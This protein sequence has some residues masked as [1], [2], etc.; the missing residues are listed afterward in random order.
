[1]KRLLVMLLC[2][3]SAAGAAVY[4]QT[5]NSHYSDA[6][7]YVAKGDY[8]SAVKKFTAART[9][10]DVKKIDKDSK[11]YLNVNDQ[12]SK[13]E[14]CIELS[15]TAKENFAPLTDK[16]LDNAIKKC[17]SEEDARDLRN[18]LSAR[19]I[20]ARSALS[21][22]HEMF[23]ADNAAASRLEA[24]TEIENRIDNI[25]Y[26]FASRQEE[27][28]LWDR[29]SQSETLEAYSYYLNYFPEGVHSKE[30]AEKVE[31]LE[32]SDDWE[33]AKRINTT[34]SYEY[35]IHHHPSGKYLAE[36][37][38]ARALCR[39]D[40]FWNQLA[41][42]NTE[43]AYRKYL[44]KYPAGR[45]AGEANGRIAEQNEWNRAVAANTIE[46]YQ[47]YLDNSTI[48][49]FKSEAEDKIVELERVRELAEDEQIWA[50]IEGSDDPASFKRYLDR[51]A[52]K[53]HES[54][55][56]AK[57]WTLLARNIEFSSE[58]AEKIVEA[59]ATAAKYT[60]LGEADSEC[61]NNAR[62]LIRYHAFK[63]DPSENSA[64]AYLRYFPDGIYSDAVSSYIA[65]SKADLFSMYSSEAD[66]ADALS[67]ART[68]TSQKYVKDK[69]KEAQRRLKQMQRKQNAE[70]MHFK[71]GVQCFYFA[72]EE[73]PEL[74]AGLFLGLG[75]S[76][77]RINMELG[78][79][80]YVDLT[81]DD[82]NWEYYDMSGF[83]EGETYFYIYVS[84]KLNI[85]KRRY[86]GKAPA[87]GKRIEFDYSGCA[88]YI[89]PEIMI[90]P[91]L[92]RTN[93]GIRTG[94]DF[95]SFGFSVGYDRY[96]RL[97]V[98]ASL[99]F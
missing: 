91:G 45:Y 2:L 62:E 96:K 1:M 50:E 26:L 18:R 4:A 33:A 17:S 92:A 8:E 15:K 75:N 51:Y 77:N 56:N 67:Y 10:L 9:Y 84:P 55:A 54:E 34:G 86:L 90:F 49:A 59:Y 25:P 98:G 94:L 6:I 81:D 93:Y 20:V 43:D 60:T 47:E 78:A 28:N 46:A 73:S 65:T 44:A 42:L 83:I 64:K 53:G 24:C 22:I 7:S 41:S 31:R 66:Y 14:K 61:L 99:F 3:L 57:Y 16:A 39:E 38:D 27:E 82:D 21:D 71:F 72:G 35:Y 69:Y 58:N 80:C 89:A 74:D 68:D 87:G 29:V 19:L 13:A 12:I 36:A 79:G 88:F 23:P 37:N 48:Q 97:S 40:D 5:S 52:Y 70:P 95:R 30:A 63:E 85:L 76:K 11:E 32:D